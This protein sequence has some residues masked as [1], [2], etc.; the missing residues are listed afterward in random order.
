M[1]GL[2]AWMSVC[3]VCVRKCLKRSEEGVGSPKLNLQVAVSCHVGAGNGPLRPSARAA[4]C[5][6]QCRGNSLSHRHSCFMF[7]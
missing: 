5:A 7:D 6:P 3:N 1:G 2:P 4:A